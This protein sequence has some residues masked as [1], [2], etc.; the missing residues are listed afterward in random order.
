MKETDRRYPF[1]KRGIKKR[2]SNK[3]SKALDEALNTIMERS[4]SDYILLISCADYNDASKKIPLHIMTIELTII[5][6]SMMTVR[7]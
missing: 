1:L 4:I 2:I 3:V 5:Q 7:L 6:A